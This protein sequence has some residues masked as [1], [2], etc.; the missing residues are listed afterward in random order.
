MF[1]KFITYFK[2][3]KER[4]YTQLWEM[5]YGD[6]YGHD[7]GYIREYNFAM[8]AAY[9]WKQAYDALREGT[10]PSKEKSDE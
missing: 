2:R 10:R 8:E 6:G 5:L 7:K 4:S 1:E 9:A 3:K